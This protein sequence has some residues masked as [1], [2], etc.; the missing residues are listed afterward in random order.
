MPCESLVHAGILCFFQELV[1]SKIGI[2]PNE[3]ILCKNEEGDQLNLSLCLLD[4]GVRQ[5]NLCDEKSLKK[6][7]FQT[8]IPK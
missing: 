1:S 8:L 7:Q 2:G 6:L 4:G 5:A 3:Q